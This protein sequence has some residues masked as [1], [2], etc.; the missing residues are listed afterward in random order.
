MKSQIFLLVFILSSCFV[1]TKEKTV[2]AN[3]SVA[4]DTTKKEAFRK[5]KFNTEP[6]TWEEKQN[7]LRD[8]ILNSKPNTILKSDFLQEFYIRGIVSQE[9][10][11][12]KFDLP[13]NLHSLDCGAPDCYT[14][15][16]SF[17]IPVAKANDFPKKV[18]CQLYEEG[19]ISKTPIHK[20]IEFSL[21]EKTNHSLNYYSDAE[22]SNLVLIGNKQNASIYYF[23]NVEANT[24]KVN[25]VEQLLQEYDE[26]NPNNSFPYQIWKMT[27]NEYE[28]F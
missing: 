22:K 12:I 23:T 11:N 10:N 9:E 15:N 18:T 20:T 8:S 16:L 3:T 25:L 21:F 14:T 26:Q 13:F 17:V 2:Q 24:I 7:N 6:K 19:C 27:T 28:N 5:T 1:Q 4:T